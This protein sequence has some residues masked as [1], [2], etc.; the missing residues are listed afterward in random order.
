V[1][2]FTERATL[3]VKDRSTA[4][5]RRIN[6]E[7]K[8][9][10][11]TSRSLKSIRIQFI[12]IAAATRQVNQLTRA[13]QRLKSVA[14]K[15]IR[16]NVSAAGLGLVQRQIST[17]R[18]SARRP[19]NVRVN[20]TGNRPPIIPPGGGGGPGAGGRAG[21]RAGR[22]RTFFGTAMQGANAGFGGGMGLG[23]MGGL[24]AVNPAMLAVAAAAYLAAAALRKI[25]SETLKAD[26]ADLMMRL[27]ATKN[28]QDIINKAVAD[29][30][31]ETTHPLTM[32]R[33]EM[34][35][36]ITGI[37]GDV[38]GK[39]DTERATAAAGIAPK[40]VD[41]FLPLAYGLGGI[42]TTRE[43][44]MSGLVTIVKGLNIA[45]GDL[46][47][48]LGNF[49]KDGQ[50]V[51]EGIALAKAM[52]PNLEAERIRTVLANLKTAAFTMDSTALARVLASGG[53]RG[54]RVA[55]EAYMAM[56]AMTG[57]VDNKALNKALQKM[58]LLTGGI[59]ITD[60]KGRPLKGARAGIQPGSGT[61]V[62]SDLLRTDP[63]EWIMKHVLPRA[64]KLAETSLT[65]KETA[66]AEAR[67][68]QVREEGGTEEEVAAARAPLRSRI[69]T[70]LDQMFPGL[71][72]PARTA[73]SET[74]FGAEQAKST[75]AQGKDALKNLRE[76]GKA[77]FD[78]SLSAA[79]SNIGTTLSDKAADMGKSA[80]DAI[81]LTDAINKINAAL[82]DPKGKDREKLLTDAQR[83]WD[84]TP[85]GLASKIIMAGAE[86]IYRAAA[87]MASWI[88][89]AGK[90][91]TK[92][93]TW[94]ATKGVEDQ[95]NL[96]AK[97]LAD[98]TIRVM[99]L[100][101]KLKAKER[102][103]RDT[104]A[105]RTAERKA[106]TDEIQKITAAIEEGKANIA[107]L[108]EYL[109]QK[110]EEEK[111]PAEVKPVID[112][113]DR[114][115]LD[116]PRN[117]EGQPIKV[118]ADIQSMINSIDTAP[119][120]FDT[121]FATLPTKGGEGG[122][123]FSNNAMTAINSGAPG[124]GTVIGNAAVAAIKAGVSNLNIN[125]NANVKSGDSAPDTGARTAVG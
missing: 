55:N 29:Y 109:Q 70:V 39:T 3:E 89:G 118:P 56:R 34:K 17:L 71:T 75:T 24:A 32:T 123:N 52:N 121:A 97:N 87:W 8:K 26:K 82:R 46:T 35:V 62:D 81:G 49:T 103:L 1:A 42:D 21:R 54:V 120:K 15:A 106:L 107:G 50:R 90:E 74:I 13:V 76:Q 72:G 85:M 80:A 9:L 94:T 45:S 122:T 40:I 23:L 99:G 10:Q 93:A 96:D 117:K 43:Q 115:Q 58:D 14:G 92:S 6:A 4:Q 110:K 67:A 112:D 77:I 38:G 57:I 60:S 25:G 84:L 91:P 105:R 18:N 88:P 7:L 114:D 79:L 108:K 30:A 37:L 61:P 124:A 64:K 28:Q 5:I 116:I 86:L 11:A 27:A 47:D 65:K 2:S 48:A 16:V 69:Q 100:E 98:E 59:P 36:F 119:S 78:A 33:A 68:R 125:V 19:V 12:G 44:A 102:T 53:D 20:Y 73:I 51:F 104:P 63:F 113:A 31:T 41:T 95:A 111:K 22:G 101:Q 66:A 83:A